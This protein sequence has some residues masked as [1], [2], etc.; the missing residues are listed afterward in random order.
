MREDLRLYINDTEVEFSTGPKIL[1]NY[2]ETDLTNPTIVKNSYSK[3]VDIPGTERNNDLF[4]HIWDL[5]RVQY[6]STFNPLKK[7]PFKLYV[8]GNLIE[9]G[10]CKL[11]KVTRKGGNI[12]YSVSLYGGL[13]SFLYNLAYDEESDNDRKKTLNDLK[14]VYLFD[15][16]PFA[17]EPDLNFVI[18]KETILDAWETQVGG[19]GVAVGHSPTEQIDKWRIINF[20]P[21]YNGIPDDFDADKV[22]INHSGITTTASSPDTNHQILSRVKGNAGWVYNGNQITTINGRGWC[23]G[24]LSQPLTE[25]ETKDL[26]SYLQRPVLNVYRTILAMTAPE[27][28]G[29]YEV[30]L[31]DHFFNSNNP[32]FWDAWMTLPMLTDLELPQGQIAEVTGATLTSA[33]TRWYINYS[34]PSGIAQLNAARLR[35]N[36][37]L[38]PTYGDTATASTLYMTHSWKE[39]KSNTIKG[40]T[41]VRTFENVVGFTI[42]A[43]ARNNIGEIIAQ[44]PAYYLSQSKTLPTGQKIYDNFWKEGDEGTKPE[45]VWLPGIWKLENGSYYFA[46]TNGNRQS[47]DFNIP[48][49]Q[50]IASIEFKTQT[51][52]GYSVKYKFTGSQSMS[53]FAN[54]AVPLYDAQSV[55]GNGLKTLSQVQASGRTR[56]GLRLVLESF[57]G[58]A[59]DVEGLISGTYVPREKLLATP[60]SPADF[61][62]SYT[63]MFGLYYYY[64]PTEE[65]SDPNKYPN[66]VIHILDRAEF[67]KMVDSEGNPTTPELI[68]IDKLIDRSKNMEITPIAAE[69]KFYNFE[70]E[71]VES[72]AASVYDSTYGHTYGRQ[73]VNTGYNFDSSVKD[74]YEGNVFKSAPMVLEQD[75]YFQQIDSSTKYQSFISQG[76]KQVLFESTVS[77]FNGETEEKTIEKLI[78]SISINPD[79]LKNYDLFP[80]MQLH[81]ADN[82]A[83]DGAY[84]LCFGSYQT[85]S[86]E[87][88]SEGGYY[89]LTDDIPEMLSVNDG[90]PCWISTYSD[91]VYPGN[92]IGWTIHTLPF[93]SRD[94]ISRTEGDKF[95]GLTWNFGNPRETFM[96]MTYT[97]TT[98]PIYNRCWK[99]YIGD[100]Y[101]VNTR[102]LN[103]YINL[104]DRPNGDA[105]RRFYWF[106][107][108]IW[109][110]NEVKDWNIFGFDST[111]CEFIKVQDMN[112]YSLRPM[113]DCPDVNVVFGTVAYDEEYAYGG[114]SM[115]D[116]GYWSTADE[117]VR[118]QYL[119]GARFDVDA[120]NISPTNGEGLTTEVSIYFG[121]VN[122][123]ALPRTISFGAG[124][125]CG[126]S[127]V[128]TWGGATQEGNGDPYIAM[129]CDTYKYV[130][131][132]GEEMRTIILD[133]TKAQEISVPL[134]KFRTTP[135]DVTSESP[136]V[137]DCYFQGNTVHIKVNENT[138][139][140]GRWGYVEISGIGD[141]DIIYIDSVYIY[142]PS[143]KIT[144]VGNNQW[145]YWQTNYNDFTVNS[146][147][148]YSSQIKNSDDFEIVFQAGNT[149]RV[150]PISENTGTTAKT[151]VLSITNGVRTQN[152]T[153]TQD[154]YPTN[155]YLYVTWPTGAF[156]STGET[157]TGS[158]S[159]NINWSIRVDDGSDW[160]TATKTSSTAFRI[161]FTKNTM[162][163]TRSA[164]I[165]IV[166]GPGVA[167]Q[168]KTY[169]QAG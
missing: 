151:A 58:E 67:F 132:A 101:G 141:D 107:N 83:E 166:G 22:L 87:C 55:T 111:L 91:F 159:S 94:L 86:V 95:I 155:P 43:L 10:Y 114:V 32:Y 23:M 53:T 128:E 92:R 142:Q 42:Q 26:R 148:P 124:Y 105:M 143:A 59:T 40:N 165:R 41:Y 79:G 140:S 80:K 73:L 69:A 1:Y 72:E 48:A 78:P 16:A 127:E 120:D 29:G 49:G 138:T 129:Y 145:N 71:S 115:S 60:F 84:V 97:T 126:G 139:D 61:L 54:T 98:G 17:E 163:A 110:L 9:K 76:F 45:Y 34:L 66:G 161:K 64:D 119:N 30:D 50:E 113:N 81:S 168:T 109:R 2:K 36:P 133:D 153:L 134:Y 35:V 135:E 136:M 90:K 56:G 44:S 157:K 96:P 147:L 12:T 160:C 117:Y 31:G 68:D 24:E 130:P 88:V 51:A 149:V 65:S 33:D 14:F 122:D 100:L 150:K 27:N 162:G 89:H 108:C 102:K 103:C 11:N 63:K 19:S 39:T 6:G 4:G 144:Y 46:D 15:G 116:G 74:L 38:A 125:Y 82:S 25:W 37:R 57:E 146:E 93:F 62:L 47:I 21:C 131:E 75:R 99:D 77:S 106:D 118:G 123:S 8:G 169:N 137:D 156:L 154:G 3:T 112:N 167:A 164:T 85:S 52:Y 158:V 121:G 104:Q 18:N 20:A 5:E 70:Q 13:G 7:T 28:N 152:I